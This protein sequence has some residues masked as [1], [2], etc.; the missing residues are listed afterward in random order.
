MNQLINLVLF[1][2]RLQSKE[3]K[4]FDVRLPNIWIKYKLPQVKTAEMY[5]SWT[6]T[7]Q[8]QANARQR[9]NN[10]IGDSPSLSGHGKRNLQ[11]GFVT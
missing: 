6:L 7:P 1:I 9:A 11:A 4:G 5:D 2:K 8:P 10:K 3:V